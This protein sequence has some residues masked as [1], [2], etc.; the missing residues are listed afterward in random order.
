MH[1]LPFW[2]VSHIFEFRFV[3]WRKVSRPAK[4]RRHSLGNSI[5]DLPV[6][7]SCRHFGIV[8]E[9]RILN[10]SN[11][12]IKQSLQCF[13]LLDE[14]CLFLSMNPL[15]LSQFTLFY[16]T[17]ESQQYIFGDLEGLLRVKALFGFGLGNDLLSERCSVCMVCTF[18]FACTFTDDG[19]G[20]D[21]GRSCC[22]LH[23][24]QC[25]VNIIVAVSV[26]LHDI[27]VLR[28]ETL[29]D[30]FAPCD[31]SISL[32][33]DLVG[34]VDEYKVFES[35][36]S[37]QGTGFIGD[38][39]LQVTITAEAVDLVVYELTGFGVYLIGSKSFCHGKSDGIGDPLSQRTCRNLDTRSMS[40]F[41]VSGRF[42][43]ELAKIL[44]II[45]ADIVAPEVKQRVDKPRT[46]PSGEYQTVTVEP[47]W[48]LG[49]VVEMFTQDHSDIR[50]PHRCTRVPRICFLYHVC[51]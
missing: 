9:I 4:E 22:R 15:F 29:G 30:I 10:R 21:N 32:D 36:V 16:S 37:C 26:D 40:V 24:S 33:R 5:E 19:I 48:V 3:R 2:E 35:K 13:V 20:N 34:V 31:G 23:F 42:G 45:Q 12:R 41:G 43:V 6:G 28:F 51:R 39:L 25:L 50:K 27:P 17:S 47:F 44:Q 49:V 18:E 11:I 14:R 38:T 7:I 1:V 8:A 46:V